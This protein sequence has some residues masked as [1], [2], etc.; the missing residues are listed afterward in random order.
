MDIWFAYLGLGSYLPQ[1]PLEPE[2]ERWLVKAYALDIYQIRY[3]QK[4]VIGS[5]FPNAY[6]IPSVKHVKLSNVAKW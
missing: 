1:T 6:E 3:I 4:K 2:E 5:K